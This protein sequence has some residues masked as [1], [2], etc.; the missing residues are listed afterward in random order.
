MRNAF[1]L[2]LAGV[3]CNFD[4]ATVTDYFAQQGKTN[5]F[6]ERKSD[7]PKVA[8][9]A[10]KT[11]ENV[12]EKG[13]HSGNIVYTPCKY[14]SE[15]I[16]DLKDRG[17]IVIYSNGTSIKTLTKILDDIS[18]LD[19]RTIILPGRTF[20]D[21]AQVQSHVKTLNYLREADYLPRMFIDDQRPLVEAAAKA[22][23]Q[24]DLYQSFL[25]ITMGMPHRVNVL[26]GHANMVQ[27]QDWE[28]LTDRIESGTLIYSDI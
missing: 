20:G 27:V 4:M 22:A 1:I 26:P 14:V 16:E 8:E 21:K 13:V 9:E 7:D 15:G 23:F 19:G 17:D 11:F 3:I 2:D 10:E 5:I 24:S 25:G 28:D 18:P 12:L 6:S